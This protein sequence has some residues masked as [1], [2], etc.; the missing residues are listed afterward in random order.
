MNIS[1]HDKAWED[2]CYWQKYDKKIIKRINLLLKDI[3]RNPFS[4]KGKPELLKYSY[5]GFY[6]RRITQEHPLVYTI[7]NDEIKVAQCRFHYG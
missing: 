4:G 6:S 1:F 5:T 3:K 2:Y 7:E